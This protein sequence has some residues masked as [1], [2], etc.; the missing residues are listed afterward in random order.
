MRRNKEDCPACFMKDCDCDCVIC[1]VNRE[2]NRILSQDRLDMLN[3]A[4]AMMVKDDGKKNTKS[5]A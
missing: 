4:S 5:P 2:K 1:T 3:F